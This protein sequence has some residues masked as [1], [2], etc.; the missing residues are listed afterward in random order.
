MINH[1]YT[2]SMTP[3]TARSATPPA[4]AGRDVVVEVGRAVDGLG[5]QGVAL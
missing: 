3:P 5:P 2:D 1:G 4:Y